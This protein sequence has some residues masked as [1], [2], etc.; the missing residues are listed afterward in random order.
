MSDILIRDVPEKVKRELKR[1]AVRRGN[2]LSG[3]LR[4]ACARLA[5]EERQL[6]QAAK[7]ELD[8][9]GLGTRLAEI[10]RGK[11]PPDFKIPDFR[12]EPVRTPKFDE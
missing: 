9:R 1:R 6:R 2:S 8:P 11:V 3:E 10:F 7:D 5:E 4:E 12:S